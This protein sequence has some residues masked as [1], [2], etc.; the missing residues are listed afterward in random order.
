[1]LSQTLIS[2]SEGLR[3]LWHLNLNDLA[4]ESALAIN[5]AVEPE[6]CLDPHVLRAV[7][8][9]V[10]VLISELAKMPR[11]V[12][13]RGTMAF[14]VTWIVQPKLKKNKQLLGVWSAIS[15]LTVG[16][17]TLLTPAYHRYALAMCSLQGC[18]HFGF[19]VLEML[20]RAKD[21]API[22]YTI[23]VLL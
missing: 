4:Y 12:N 11:F 16:S 2:W 3:F 17:S 18:L 6:A 19:A 20:C 15:F 14:C 13:G 23:D 9:F 8:F 1:M 7:W 10:L 21:G 22:I 5:H